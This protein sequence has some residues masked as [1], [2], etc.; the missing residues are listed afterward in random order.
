MYKQ[1]TQVMQ[2]LV[3]FKKIAP[4][5][6]GVKETIEKFC[7]LIK[8]KKRDTSPFC[9]TMAWLVLNGKEFK[10]SPKNL[11]SKLISDKALHQAMFMVQVSQEGKQT[12]LSVEDLESL[13]D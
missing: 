6:K 9:G 3:S 12:T 5:C 4:D 7:S 11:I 2:Y 10:D 8:E 1:A 13:K